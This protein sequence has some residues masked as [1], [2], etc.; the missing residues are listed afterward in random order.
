MKYKFNINH[1]ISL[2]QPREKSIDTIAKEL[3]ALGIN[4]RTFYRDR[5]ITIND[6]VDIPSYR[7][8]IYAKYFGVTVTQ[9]L[10]YSVSKT[11]KIKNI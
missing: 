1:Y 11:G 3:L 10:N 7:L 6:V 4:E 5:V 8:I 2:T 9:M